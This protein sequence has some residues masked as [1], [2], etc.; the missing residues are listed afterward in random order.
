MLLP[1]LLLLLLMMP[2]HT[3]ADAIAAL[4]VR[5]LLCLLDPGTYHLTS[6]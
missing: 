2:L 6:S 5:R 1:P 4:H 3:A